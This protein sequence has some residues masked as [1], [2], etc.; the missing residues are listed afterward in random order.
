[1]RIKC[2]LCVRVSVSACVYGTCATRTS[3]M[4]H[5]YVWTSAEQ[6]AMASVPSVPMQR[7]DNKGEGE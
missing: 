1:M 7:N 6:T 3:G 5:P 4:S 2:V